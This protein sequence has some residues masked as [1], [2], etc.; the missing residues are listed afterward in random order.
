M[1]RRPLLSAIFGIVLCAC[2]SPREE[3]MGSSRAAVWNGVPA[4]SWFRAD[5]AAVTLTD[6][7]VLVSG[8]QDND[9]YTLSTAQLFDPVSKTWSNAGSMLELRKGHRLTLLPSGKVLATCGSGVGPSLSVAEVYDPSLN[10]WSTAGTASKAR[11]RHRAVLVGTKV[12][13]AIGIDDSGFE[14]TDADLYDPSNNSW[15]KT[16]ALV[17]AGRNLGAMVALPGGSAL[18]FGGANQTG[19]LST[20]EIWSQSTGAFASTGSMSVARGTVDGFVITTPSGSRVLVA[21]GPVQSAEL[22]DPATGMWS[23]APAPPTFQKTYQGVK[24]VDGR[25]L[26]SGGA[27]ASNAVVN[28]AVIFDPVTM[29]WSSDPM[30]S[31]RVLHVAA[32]LPGGGALVAGGR[33]LLTGANVLSS[34]ELL[35]PAPGADAGPMDTSSALVDA[36]VSEGAVDAAIPETSVADTFTPDTTVSDTRVS[37]SDVADTSVADTSV[38]DTDVVDTAAITDTAPADSGPSAVDTGGDAAGACTSD[39]MCP[40]SEWC[41]DGVCTPRIPRGDAPC[42]V[43]IPGASSA[44]FGAALAVLAMLGAIA[45][46][47]R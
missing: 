47:R 42:S 25:V 5:L 16:G 3:A 24:L 39:L 27:N 15:T 11:T 36:I 46:R 28:S 26:L 21:G 10:T 18:A 9:G 22:F 13:V 6:G 7:R 1:S 34:A 31:A 38:A 12:L 8:G 14:I 30:S 23:A 43:A 33:T 40:P 44:D 37:D 32:A 19:T 45:R 20:A 2:S 4:M 17:G 35:V 41:D 29:T